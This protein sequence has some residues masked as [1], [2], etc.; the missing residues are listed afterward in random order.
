MRKTV[1][2]YTHDTPH[3]THTH[4]TLHA[5]CVRT[6]GHV[7]HRYTGGSYHQLDKATYYGTFLPYISKL[8]ANSIGDD[9]F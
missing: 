8:F 7:G 4:T 6:H 9:A 2:A 3:V 1:T 5:H